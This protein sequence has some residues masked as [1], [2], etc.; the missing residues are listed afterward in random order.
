MIPLPHQSELGR[1][2]DDSWRFVPMA[3]SIQAAMEA[4]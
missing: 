3:A 4:V 2:R 1:H